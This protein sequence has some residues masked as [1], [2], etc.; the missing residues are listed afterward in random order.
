MVYAEQG[1]VN[2]ARICFQ[3]AIRCKPDYADAHNNLSVILRRR[4]QFEAAEVSVREA[5]RL[6]PDYAEALNNLGNV[7]RDLPG[8]DRQANLQRAIACFEA[9]SQVFMVAGVD[10]YLQVVKRNL[11][12]AR[13]E[14]EGLQ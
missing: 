9:A 13:Q 7:Y 14:L 5:L 6:K 12:R 4:G 3:R 1:E 10:Y 8:G 11:E 2:E